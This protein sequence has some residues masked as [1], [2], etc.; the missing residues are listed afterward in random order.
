MVCC[1]RKS[2]PAVCPLVKPWATRCA[3]AYSV[4]VSSGIAR[5]RWGRRAAPLS[6]VPWCSPD[7]VARGVSPGSG[8]RVGVQRLSKVARGGGP[9]VGTTDEHDSDVLVRRC[10]RPGIDV[11]L[12][13][14]PELAEVLVMQSGG[15]GRGRGLHRAE[16][17]VLGGQLLTD[18]HAVCCQSSVTAVHHEPDEPGQRRGFGYREL[19]HG[20][21]RGEQLGAQRHGMTPA[22]LGL[23][24]LDDDPGRLADVDISLWKTV[25][26]LSFCV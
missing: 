2:R 15:V 18:L 3:T 17:R 6:A 1:D 26:S 23:D 25:S 8:L 4:S 5:L 19:A 13:R 9:V 24:D 11:R 16:M 14:E 22:L 20:R 7:P 12:G 10:L 21:V